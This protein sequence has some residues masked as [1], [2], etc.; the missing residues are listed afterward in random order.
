MTV[1]V[2]GNDDKFTGNTTYNVLTLLVKNFLLKNVNTADVVIVQSVDAAGPGSPVGYVSVKS[3]VSQ[4]DAYGEVI[5]TVEFFRLPYLRIQGGVA[6]IVCDPQPGDIGIA[7]Y[8]K[9]DS[10]LVQQQQQQPVRPGT[11]NSFDQSSG[12]YIGGFLNKPAQVYVEM[13]QDGNINITAPSNVNISCQ[14]ATV[15]ANDKI[16]LD[17]PETEVT[18]HLSVGNGIDYNGNSTASGGGT[19]YA[20][21]HVSSGISGNSHT[22]GGVETGGGTTGGPQ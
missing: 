2:K 11:F 1:A 18:G 10:S 20:T 14:T 5:P 13:T 19:S 15:A 7:V 17:A 3:L 22:H 9:R 16:T 4:V 8:T 21:D 12:F 6:A